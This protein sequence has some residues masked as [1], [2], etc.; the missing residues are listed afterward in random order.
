MK[1]LKSQNKRIATFVIEA[2][3]GERIKDMEQ[4]TTSLLERSRGEASPYCPAHE[5]PP[6]HTCPASWQLLDEVAAEMGLETQAVLNQLIPMSYHPEAVRGQIRFRVM[7][8]PR[9]TEI[10]RP[11]VEALQS[12]LPKPS[13]VKRDLGVDSHRTRSRA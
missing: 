13:A 8:T 3:H 7:G 4:R 2:G 9:R 1:I 11:D 6:N 5:F 12:R 10:W